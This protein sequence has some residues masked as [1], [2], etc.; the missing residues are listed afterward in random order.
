MND[1]DITKRTYKY[2]EGDV[3]YPF[4]YGLSY[5]SFKY[6]NMEVKDCGETYNVSLKVRNTGRRDG[7]QVVKVFSRLPEYEGKAPV[8]ELK[9]FQRVY[10]PKGKTVEVHIPVRKSDLRYWSESRSCFVHPEGMP[11][12]TV[13]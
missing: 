1:Y 6:S 8:K 11:E 12:F 2:F 3:L 9:G 13:E 7:G 5:T 10:V 4:G